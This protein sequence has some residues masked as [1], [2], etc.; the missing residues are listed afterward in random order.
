MFTGLPWSFTISITRSG[1]V[2]VNFNKSFVVFLIAII[3]REYE[4]PTTGTDTWDSF[5]PWE[6]RVHCLNCSGCFMACWRASRIK[7]SVSDSFFRCVSSDGEV[8]VTIFGWSLDLGGLGGS[9][10][11]SGGELTGVFLSPSDALS[12]EIV[13]GAPDCAVVSSLLSTSRLTG[14][15]AARLRATTSSRL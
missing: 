10:G 12:T 13:V 5:R 7:A 15:P 6:G 9:E 8:G 11:K 1:P 3:A 2:D 14:S 4:C